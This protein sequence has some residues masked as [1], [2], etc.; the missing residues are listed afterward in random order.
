MAGRGRHIH[1]A[2]THIVF[3]RLPSVA[4]RRRLFLVTA[5]SVFAAVLASY[6]KQSGMTQA[7]AAERFLM[8]KSL[9][10]KI[11][12]CDRKPQRDFAVRCDEVFSA[13]GVFACIYE[14]MITEP[15]PAWF[16]PR[17]AYE[18]RASVITDWEQRGIPGRLQTEDYARA[19]IRACRPYDPLEA[20]EHEVR[21]RLERQ[22]ILTR[23]NPPNLWVVIAERVLRQQVG[24]R[25]VMTAQLEHLI[26][27]ADS[28]RAVIQILPFTAADAPG[29][30]GP[31]TL[32]EFRQD[33]PVA[34]LEGW[35]TGRVVE[36]PKDVAAIATALSMIKGC[37]MSPGDSKSLMEQIRS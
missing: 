27:I 32:F 22:D 12:S 24:N 31:A 34:Y 37:A 4:V 14:D 33:Q 19:V 10:Q 29:A 23:D 3:V 11:E 21:S 17:V 16:G 9:Y 35:G 7:D 30:D 26:K 6:R 2:G 13:P 5:R 36:D 18:D 15:Y 28:P 1:R 20:L 25:D 8:S